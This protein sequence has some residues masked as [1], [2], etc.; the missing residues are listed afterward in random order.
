[1]SVTST[2][3]LATRSVNRR[4][5]RPNRMSELWVE[6]EDDENV[7]VDHHQTRFDRWAVV[8]CLDYCSRLDNAESADGSYE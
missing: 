1:M 4:R 8:F 5:P 7:T 2:F 3:L 6:D